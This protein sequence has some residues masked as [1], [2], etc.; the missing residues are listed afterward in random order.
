MDALDRGV[1]GAQNGMQGSWEVPSV[2]ATIEGGMQHSVPV[3]DG[4]R[5]SNV[6]VR[7]TLL[8]TWTS[9]VSLCVPSFDGRLRTIH[10]Y[11]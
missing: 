7:S 6:T 1:D 9:P 3:E 4:K 8:V 10:C 11:H 5:A 2:D